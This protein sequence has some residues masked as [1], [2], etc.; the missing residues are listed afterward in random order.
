MSFFSKMANPGAKMSNALVPKPRG[1]V[2]GPPRMKMP[3]IGGD[4]QL[5]SGHGMMRSSLSPKLKP[6]PTFPTQ[7]SSADGSLLQSLS[8]SSGLSGIRRR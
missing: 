7:P 4:P 1:G 6:L 2:I 3:E 8:P 5:R